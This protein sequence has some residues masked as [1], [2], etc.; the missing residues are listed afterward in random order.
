MISLFVIFIAALHI[1]PPVLGALIA[2]EKG[3]KKGTII[4]CIIA[5]FA[6]ALIF[7]VVDLIGVY[8][9]YNIGKSLCNK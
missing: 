4:G 6:G 1:I 3:L 2:G 9:G 5:I 8:I 7:S